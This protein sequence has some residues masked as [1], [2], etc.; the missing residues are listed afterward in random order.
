MRLACLLLLGLLAGILGQNLSPAPPEPVVAIYISFDTLGSYATGELP[1]IAVVKFVASVDLIAGKH[2][3]VIH[4]LGSRG[5]IVPGRISPVSTTIFVPGIDQ[6]FLNGTIV[7]PGVV[8]EGKGQDLADIFF[9][10]GFEANMISTMPVSLIGS[11]TPAGRALTTLSGY[12]LLVN[13]VGTGRLKAGVQYEMIITQR[14][15]APNFPC[16]QQMVLT[17][18]GYL[19]TALITLPLPTTVSSLLDYLLFPIEAAVPLTYTCPW[20]AVSSLLLHSCVADTNIQGKQIN[21]FTLTFQLGVIVTAGNAIG[22][23]VSVPIFNDVASTAVVSL[24]YNCAGFPELCCSQSLVVVRRQTSASLTTS[25]Y[26]TVGWTTVRVKLGPAG[27]MLPKDKVIS[28]VFSSAFMAKMPSIPLTWDLINTPYQAGVAIPLNCRMWTSS[29]PWPHNA[30]YLGEP[31]HPLSNGLTATIVSAGTIAALANPRLFS[32]EIVSWS[33]VVIGFSTVQSVV[34]QV[35][36]VV[37]G[38]VP[39]WVKVTFVLGQV[40]IPNKSAATVNAFL[41]TFTVGVVVPNYASAAAPA[42][43]GQGSRPCGNMRAFTNAYASIG[44]LAN[45]LFDPKGISDSAASCN[46]A[47][48]QG[49]TIVLIFGAEFWQR[50]PAAGTQVYLF[51]RAVDPYTDQSL[52]LYSQWIG[53]GWTGPSISSVDTATLAMVPAWFTI[54]SCGAGTVFA[55]EPGYVTDIWSLTVDV[56]CQLVDAISQISPVTTGLLQCP[57]PS[58]AT[59]A[60]NMVS[61]VKV[62]EAAVTWAN[63]PWAWVANVAWPVLVSMPGM[64]EKVRIL[65]F[66]WIIDSPM[67]AVV[68]SYPPVSSSL[69]TL[70]V[71]PN[72][73]ST[74]TLVVII[75]MDRLTESCQTLI[76]DPWEFLVVLGTGANG[77]GIVQCL[78]FPADGSNLVGTPLDGVTWGS[79]IFIVPADGAVACWTAVNVSPTPVDDGS[80]NA[81]FGLLALIAVPI[82]CCYCLLA[83]LWFLRP[84]REPPCCVPECPVQEMYWVSAQQ[85]APVYMVEQA[86]CAPCTT[87]MYLVQ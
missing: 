59:N 65:N 70:G 49:A 63:W 25:F 87:P 67:F 31:R 64:F 7:N 22:I 34:V 54:A 47:L 41:L 4:Y 40:N 61:F 26:P 53:G 86:C 56:R 55:Y 20:I 32:W 73:P 27:C 29:E 14:V 51:I 66:G 85:P 17:S 39:E 50:N 52:K 11:V 60:N 82:L 78:Y 3:I 6:S 45:P 38:V 13:L 37:V 36:S 2:T 15:L 35:A 9:T 72:V 19:E 1:V 83:L 80:D 48:V 71:N 8:P 58:V 68:V 57:D 69:K 21:T 74:W 76:Y 30:L 10:A 77:M 42:P 84:K 62:G 33:A 43:L 79:R 18:F 75:R 16:P 5:T 24:G 44:A 81:L 46:A 28:L 12:T 23:E